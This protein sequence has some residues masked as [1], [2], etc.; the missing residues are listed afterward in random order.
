MKYTPFSIKNQEFNK[1]VRGFDKEEVHAFLE[2][3]ADEFERLQIEN[4]KLQKQNEE[5]NQQIVE[6]RKIEKNLQSTLINAHESSSKAVE[7]AK[8]QTQLILKEGELKAQQIIE[9]AKTEAENI[10]NSVLKLKE[11]KNLLL[12]RLRTMVETQT[13]LLDIEIQAEDESDNTPEPSV[14]PEKK[15]DSSQINVDDILEKLL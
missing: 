15:K 7:S 9:N 6:F 14:K 8:K 13:S 3:L 11:E 5:L 10:R 1:S 12:A 2:K 4:E